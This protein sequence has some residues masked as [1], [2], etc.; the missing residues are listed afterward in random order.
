MGR[1]NFW[2]FRT[3]EYVLRL[4]EREREAARERREKGGVAR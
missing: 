4:G 1:E 3:I 2:T